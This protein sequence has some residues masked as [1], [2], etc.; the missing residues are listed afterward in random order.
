MSHPGA[1][2][3][4]FFHV[5]EEH[6]ESERKSHHCQSVAPDGESL[7]WLAVMAPNILV[8]AQETQVPGE[9]TV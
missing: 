8:P 6:T 7:P 4:F 9:N 5:L 1:P 2:K 3:L